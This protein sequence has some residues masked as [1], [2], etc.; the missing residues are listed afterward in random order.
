M[1]LR[2][3]IECDGESDR[4]ET[5]TQVVH[6]RSVWR[7]IPGRTVAHDSQINATVRYHIVVGRTGATFEGA[8][9]V[10]FEEDK[11][12]SVLTGSIELATLRPMRKLAAGA[13][14][15]HRAELRGTFQATRDPRRTVQLVNGMNR[16]FAHPD[17]GS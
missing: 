17:G 3:T 14:L 9:S 7:S 2:R 16:L 10:F 8:G 12:N 6:L 11:K 1:V 13:S 5:I 15:F 4:A